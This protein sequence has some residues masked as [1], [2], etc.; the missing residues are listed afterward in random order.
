[1]VP[2]LTNA[3][4][5]PAQPATSSV[6]SGS[7]R[8]SP[9]SSS[10][11]PNDP[12]SIDDTSVAALDDDN[13]SSADDAPTTEL[14]ADNTAL[15]GEQARL[16]C[17]LLRELPT[18]DAWTQIEAAWS[19]AFALAAEAVRLP[20]LRPDHQHRPHNAN[21]AADIQRLYTRN[22]RRAVRLIL[23][24]P[25]RQCDIPLQELHDYRVR[26]VRGYHATISPDACPSWC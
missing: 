10:A 4:T 7:G 24:G 20:P 26:E 21:N 14:P 17:S 5:P 12:G 8:T 23:E 3:A 25:S 11:S 2:H 9:S 15:L 16:L 19:Q 1:M 6:S 22:R 18:P 13:S